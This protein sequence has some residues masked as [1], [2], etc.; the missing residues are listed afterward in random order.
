ML[1]NDKNEC[2]SVASS[3]TCVNF[4]VENFREENEPVVTGKDISKI[5][6]NEAGKYILE[7]LDH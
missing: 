5:E 4:S 2:F 7:W 1:I 6:A 3:F